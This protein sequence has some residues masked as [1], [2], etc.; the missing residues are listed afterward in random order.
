MLLENNR[1]LIHIIE[2]TV[3]A[4]V[5]NSSFTRTD[6]TI[7]AGP[8]VDDTETASSYKQKIQ[9]IEIKINMPHK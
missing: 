5:F 9:F 3:Q 8:K 4:I 1:S 6:E 7:D 2:D